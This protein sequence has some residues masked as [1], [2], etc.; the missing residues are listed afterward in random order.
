[1]KREVEK[2]SLSDM[3]TCNQLSLRHQGQTQGHFKCP[4]SNMTSFVVIEIICF[5]LENYRNEKR[6]VSIKKC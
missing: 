5:I 4:L 6:I 1:M 2:K 3:V